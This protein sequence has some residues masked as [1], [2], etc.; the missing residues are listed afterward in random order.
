MTRGT[1]DH[2]IWKKDYIHA[3]PSTAFS[4]LAPN[5]L[6]IL[7]VQ[8]HRRVLDLGCGTGDISAY[9][10]DKDYDVVG[11]DPSRD[12]IAKA[13]EKYPNGRFYVGSTEE[14]LANR[15]GT[16]SNVISIE[17]VEHVYDPH[18]YAAS[19]FQLVAPGGIAIVSTPYHGYAKNLAIA[20]LG[21]YDKHHMPL[22]T[23]G[24]IKFWSTTTLR[25]LL[26]D[27]GF[28]SVAFQL[29]GRIP[30]LAKSLIAVARK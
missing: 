3:K 21:Q 27:A 19:L 12:G 11:V 9:L 2:P 24:H 4:Y 13:K 7:D 23:H 6:R 1:Q 14:N 5:I 30:P 25:A 26:V 29:V 20:L 16:F 17:V 10:E 28:S 18:E 15:F 22:K 8:P